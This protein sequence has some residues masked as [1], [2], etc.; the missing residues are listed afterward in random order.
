MK[1]RLKVSGGSEPLKIAIRGGGGGG[2]NGSPDTKKSQILLH[3]RQRATN[4]RLG[5]RFSNV[6]ILSYDHY[7][8]AARTP[9]NLKFFCMQGTGQPTRD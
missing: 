8:Y 7:N 3:A 9:K 4:T 5:R 6:K 1:T 2:A